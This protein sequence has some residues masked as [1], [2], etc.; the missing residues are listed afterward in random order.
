LK[1]NSIEEQELCVA[2]GFCCDRTLFDIAKI[3][4]GD[5]LF[6]HFEENEIVHEGRRY[7]RLPCEYF[8][9]KCTIYDKAKPKIC[10]KF[11][12]KLL[13]KAIEGEYTKEDAL[14]II[15]NT[16]TTRDE[17]VED[18]QNLMGVRKTF[19]E[20]FIQSFKD[21]SF[22]S[23]PEKKMIKYK[24]QLLDVLIAKEFKSKESFDMFYEMSEE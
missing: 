8:D 14:K 17:V 16:K 3:H 1:I 13:R 18:Y 6:G 5:K 11:K 7:F 12:C 4:D 24:A 10:S 22:D 19:R 20:I 21:E 2:C 23:S 9:T 15:S